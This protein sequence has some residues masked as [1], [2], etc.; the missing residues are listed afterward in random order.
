MA[1]PST[2]GETM[3]DNDVTLP[4]NEY[5]GL[6]EG[7]MLDELVEHDNQR[8]GV[9]EAEARITLESYNSEEIRKAWWYAIGR[10]T[11]EEGIGE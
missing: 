3:A 6:T 11:T 10:H 5:H 4:W 9:P 7:D 8:F 2:K 1:T